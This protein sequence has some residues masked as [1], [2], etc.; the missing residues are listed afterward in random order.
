MGPVAVLIGISP[1]L[2]TYDVLATRNLVSLHL[3]LLRSGSTKF[4]LKAD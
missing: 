4:L 2:L 3:V 1:R